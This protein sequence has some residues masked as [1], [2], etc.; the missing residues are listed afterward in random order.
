M[1]GFGVVTQ[2]LGVEVLGR[3]GQQM[4]ELPQRLVPPLPAGIGRQ[5][6][7]GQPHRV[8][9]LLQ[10]FHQ[11]MSGRHDPASLRLICQV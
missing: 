4:L 3:G 11:L 8:R 7:A 2:V 1:D 9:G 6:V 10:P 5:L